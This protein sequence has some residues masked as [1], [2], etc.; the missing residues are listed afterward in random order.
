MCGQTV[1]FFHTV[2]QMKG[3][4]FASWR[5]WKVVNWDGARGGREEEHKGKCQRPSP[6]VPWQ[7]QH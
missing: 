2:H 4:H 3:A 6:Q 5:A 1:H 7:V